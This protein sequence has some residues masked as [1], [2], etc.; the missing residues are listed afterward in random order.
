MAV[1][2]PIIIN[3]LDRNAKEISYT[4]SKL[5]VKTTE[6]KPT[7]DKNKWTY[8]P[9]EPDYVLIIRAVDPNFTKEIYFKT[10]EDAEKERA[11]LF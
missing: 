6:I 10:K 11:K 8:Y 1:S 5:D 4:I 2:E 7:S 9:N 3:G